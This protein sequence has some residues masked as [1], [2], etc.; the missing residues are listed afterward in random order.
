MANYIPFKSSDTNRSNNYIESQN[1]KVFPCAHRGYYSGTN[2]TDSK[3]FDPEAR[4]TTEANFT[5]TFHKLSSNKESYVISWSDGTGDRDSILKCVIGGYYFEIY[6]QDL[7]EDWFDDVDN[8]CTP[9]YLCIKTAAETLVSSLNNNGDTIDER[10]TYILSSFA[11]T[12]K[13]LDVKTATGS[14]YIFTG[15]VVRSENDTA[16]C[17]AKLAPFVAEFDY[18]GN[19]N[20]TFNETEFNNWKNNVNDSTYN[21]LYYQTVSGEWQ[22]FDCETTT[23]E[24]VTDGR[25]DSEVKLSYR[26]ASIKINSEMLP[27]TSLLDTDTGK[28]SLRMIED[29]TTAAGGNIY[30]N[31]TI[32]AGDYSVALGKH[33]TASGAISTALGDN[34]VASGV[35]S[36]AFGIEAKAT[37]K[38]AT[39]GGY[40]STAMAEVAVAFG[41]TTQAKSK[42]AVTFGTS[43]IANAENQVVIGKYNKEDSNQAFII[44][45]GDSSNTTTANKFTVSYDGNVKALG[46]LEV[47][48]SIKATGSAAN[49]L[50]LGTTETNS[51]GSIKVYGTG[52]TP[53]FQVENTGNMT[54]DGDVVINKTTSSTSTSTGALI[55]KGGAAIQENVNIAKAVSIGG[56]SGGGSSLLVSTGPTSL[57]GTL[58]VVGDSTL[59]GNLIISGTK[60]ATIGGNT[61][62]GGNF[63]VGKEKVTILSENGNTTIKG[64]LTADGACTLNNTFNVAADK[65]TA[66]GGTLVVEKSTTLKQGLTVDAGGATI[67]GNTTITGTGSISSKLTA[68]SLEV[69]NATDLKGTLTVDQ[70]TTLK[71]K[72]EIKD[73]T[74]YTASNNTAALT[75]AGGAYIAKKLYVAGDTTFRDNLE[76]GETLVRIKKDADSTAVNNGA[77]VVNGGVG[78]GKNLNVNGNAKTKNL[79]VV[80]TDGQL[81]RIQIG[82]ESTSNKGGELLIYG[83]GT[84]TVFDVDKEGETHIAGNLRVDK[85]VTITKKLTVDNAIEISTSGISGLTGLTVGGQ[86]NA[87]V[88]N[89]TSDARLK[90]NIEDYTFEKSILDLPIKRFE[91]INDKSHTKYIGCLAQDLQRI[92]PELVIENSDGM[93]SI[94]ESKLVYALLQEIKELREKVDLLERR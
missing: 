33:T 25:V 15:L 88:F 27:I 52:A 4:A 50:E 68:G 58:T 51:T 63:T 89:A 7:L 8:S 65:A 34:T 82:N 16:D 12:D 40:K 21:G 54:T 70:T 38:G 83:S 42:G 44:A 92:C 39:A 13:Y 2:G 3:V 32:A 85:A 22:R 62:V 93:L 35:G 10:Q 14:T 43:T 28:Y 17:T 41:D 48:G 84:S 73:T 79:T 76:I 53:V 91:Y 6:G 46:N 67:T 49:D 80:S 57:G 87:T 37:Q 94:H 9:K 77:L 81:N 20:K 74:D 59:K 86:I 1:I 31:T 55:V 24:A 36:V 75:I 26:Y 60:A 18:P 11:E 78:I 71:G 23:Y 47:K 66:L 61:Q 72:T 29:L 45:N 64:T 30:N 90:C 5:N 56:S 69:T 19:T